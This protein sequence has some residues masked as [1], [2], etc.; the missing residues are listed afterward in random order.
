LAKLTNTPIIIVYISVGFSTFTNTLVEA[1]PV[2][3]RM[4]QRDSF[5]VP[6]AKVKPKKPKTRDKPQ[7]PQMIAA[8]EFGVDRAI[9]Q[10]SRIQAPENS[11]RTNN[12]EA[13]SGSQY[14][15]L[16]ECLSA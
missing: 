4:A 1:L 10:K 13:S 15:W 2:H 8:K 11:R 16:L 9:I 5:R 3:S 14:S 6:G 12:L 7:I